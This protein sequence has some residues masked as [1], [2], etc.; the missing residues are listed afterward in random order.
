MRLVGAAVVGMAA[1]AAVGSAAEAG[2]GRGWVTDGAAAVYLAGAGAAVVCSEGRLLPL[3]P[4]RTAADGTVWLDLPEGPRPLPAPLA[5]AGDLTAALEPGP[6]PGVTMAVRTAQ[7]RATAVGHGADPTL[8]DALRRRAAPI[9][10]TD[11]LAAAW[12]DPV[13]LEGGWVAAGETFAGHVEWDYD[14][15]LICIVGHGVDLC[16]ATDTVA[17]GR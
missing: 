2:E 9:R 8:L 6:C 10:W 3:V 4:W 12:A 7:E 5:P 13:T 14:A 11:G 1:L 16:S 15:A 17:A